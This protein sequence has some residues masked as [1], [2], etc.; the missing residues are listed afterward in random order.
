MLS[1]IVK[2][3]E[4]IPQDQEHK[5]WTTILTQ[6]YNYIQQR[7]SLIKWSP[8][9]MLVYTTWKENNQI[10][11]ININVPENNTTTE[12]FAVRVDTWPEFVDMIYQ[13][14]PDLAVYPLRHPDTILKYLKEQDLLHCEKQR[15]YIRKSRQNYRCIDI[16]RVKRFVEAIFLP[17]SFEDEQIA[18]D[19]MLDS[20]PNGY[21]NDTDYTDE[22]EE[23]EEENGEENE[24][25]EELKEIEEGTKDTSFKPLMKRK[26][27][28]S[29]FTS[30]EEK[31]EYKYN[32]IHEHEH[33][34]DMFV[35][36]E[37]LILATLQVEKEK[38]IQTQM[39]TQI[40]EEEEEIDLINN[41]L[42]MTAIDDIEINDDELDI[43]TQIIQLETDDEM[44]TQ[45]VESANINERQQII[46]QQSESGNKNNNN[47]SIPTTNQAPLQSN[48][49]IK[50][51]S[52][53]C[54]SL[55]NLAK[56]IELN[57]RKSTQKR[58]I[59]SMTQNILQTLIDFKKFHQ[60]QFMEFSKQNEYI[61]IIDEQ[62]IK[63]KGT[64]NTNL[65]EMLLNNVDQ[66]PQ[67]LSASI[68][69][70]KQLFNVQN[71]FKENNN[72]KR[73]LLM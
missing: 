36:D 12:C 44:H 7:N 11:T 38:E 40:N 50:K 52:N 54:E 19:E 41:M 5:Y 4:A 55:N 53:L 18:L 9:N 63:K 37:E 30:E 6:L 2:R 51:F 8:K 27:I 25:D 3:L 72:R 47:H 67:R 45:L 17:S 68:N 24:E 65:I 23:D 46:N 21:T 28:K 48:Q 22:E 16:N 71:W 10:T 1:R 69:N 43:S 49:Y 15:T 62:Y 20:Q 64:V 26:P 61:K 39:S 66:L 31:D 73:K 32:Q 34:L 59:T 70:I 57:K 56:Q 42:L 35:N 33:K 58:K 60:Q 13:Q 14:S 29:S